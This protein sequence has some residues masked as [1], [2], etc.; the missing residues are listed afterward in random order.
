MIH[1][2][3]ELINEILDEIDQLKVDDPVFE[4]SLKKSKYVDVLFNK[5]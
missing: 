2:T 3:T 4:T 1:S 5:K